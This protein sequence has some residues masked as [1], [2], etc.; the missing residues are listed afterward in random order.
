MSAAFHETRLPTRLAFGGTSGV[1][2]RTEVV[3][4]ASGFERRSSPWAQGRRRYLIGTATR[5]LDEAARLVAFFEARGGRLHGFRF[6]DPTDYKSCLPSATPAPAD[7]ALGTGDGTRT[8]FALVKAYA[9]GA[10]TVLRP[11]AKPQAGSVRVAV[12]G[13]ELTAA[14]FA[15]DVNTGLV[16]LASAPAAG[17][18]VTAGFLFDTPVRFDLDRI[19]VT[20]EGFGAARVG[21]VSLVE[22]RV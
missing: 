14:A 22:V 11:I 12:A 4:L 8:V 15:V 17:A 19:D 3:G 21:A 20:L 5:S 7:Q 9:S 6:R 1:E 18:A 2:R 10:E 16:T 13:V